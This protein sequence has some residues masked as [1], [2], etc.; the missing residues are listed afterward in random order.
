MD[1]KKKFGQS[2]KKHRQN[3][4]ISQEELALKAELH[5]TYVGAIERGERNI[6]LGNIEKLAKALEISISDL[7]KNIKT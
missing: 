3:L 6:S 4:G 1:I 5:R 2:V 7:F